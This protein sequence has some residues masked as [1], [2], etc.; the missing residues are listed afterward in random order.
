M[1][2]IHHFRQWIDSTGKRILKP[3]I[4]LFAPSDTCLQQPFWKTYYKH[5]AGDKDTLGDILLYHRIRPI[6]NILKKPSKISVLS[7]NRVKLNI[8][9]DKG[10]IYKVNQFNVLQSEKYE[11]S[12]DGKTC[13]IHTI[14]NVIGIIKPYGI[15]TFQKKT[16]ESLLTS[17]CMLI[18][19]KYCHEPCVMSSWTCT[20]AS[21][22]VSS[23]NADMRYLRMLTIQSIKDY[24]LLVPVT[25][26]LVFY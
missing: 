21:S 24:L 14:D 5:I 25:Q 13:T 20:Y 18:S 9:H 11:L 16:I 10:E 12:D 3:N 17:L 1:N 19:K 8:Q 26:M 23:M 7:A 4:H 6:R 2:I 15:T 22:H